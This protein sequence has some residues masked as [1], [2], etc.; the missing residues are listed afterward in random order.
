MKKKLIITILAAVCALTCFIGLTACGEDPVAV[1]GI[2]LN[3][4]SLPLEVGGEETL[5]ATVSPNNA[6]D[7]SVSWSSSAEAV[8]TVANGKVTA[9]AEGTATITAT[10]GKQSA[11]CA[12]TVSKKD[13]GKTDTV[14]VE[15]VTLSKSSLPLEVDG[16]ETLQATVLPANATDKTV[17]WASS[18]ESVATVTDGKV[19]AVGKGTATITATA[20]NQSATCAVSVQEKFIYVESISISNSELTLEIGAKETLTITFNPANATDKTVKW[21][22]QN[23]DV[24]TV[25]GGKVTAV[26]EGTTLIIADVSQFRVACSVTVVPSVVKAERVALDQTELNMAIGDE[27]TLKATVLPNDTADKSITWTSSDTAVATVDSDG[28]VTAIAAGSA[29]ITAKTANNMSATCTVTVAAPILVESVSLNQTELTIDTDEMIRLTA[30]VLPANAVNNNLTWESSDTNIVTVV[31]GNVTGMS[32]GTAVITAK[33]GGKSATC[34]VTV[35]PQINVSW[36]SL[37]VSSITVDLDSEVTLRAE[38][39]PEEAANMVRWS[40]ENTDVATVSENGTIIPVSVG[41]TKI[42]A[43]AGNK[44]AKCTVTIVE[45]VAIENITLGKTKISFDLHD[46]GSLSD[47]E[48]NV[49]PSGAYYKLS[50]IEWTSSNPAVA[51]I[52]NGDLKALSFGT[53]TINATIDGFDIEFTVNVTGFALDYIYDATSSNMLCTIVQGSYL[54]DKDVVIPERY[55]GEK[56][57]V[58]GNYAFA[59]MTNMESI[60]WPSS[61]KTVGEYAF[62]GCTSLKIINVSYLKDIGKYAFSG[63]TALEEITLAF[64]FMTIK[65]GTFKDCS[66]LSSVE[67]GLYS[68]SI[69]SY[70]FQNCISLENFDF[71]DVSTIGKNA[72]ENTGLISVDLSRPTSISSYAFANCSKLETAVYPTLGIVRVEKGI[73]SN[74]ENLKQITIKLNEKYPVIMPNAFENCQSLEKIVFEGTAEQWYGYTKGEDWNTNTGEYVVECAGTT[75][76]KAESSANPD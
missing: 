36:F 27:K 39:D 38:V 14:A 70:A 72:F 41:T 32:Q 44:T 63:C 23:K 2:T 56:I 48:L 29:T 13:D 58:I 65:E 75:L 9:V 54:V 16:E 50:Q 11:T 20:G 22:S 59:N 71:S 18:D 34:T 17:R 51:T 66:S 26:A 33:S 47:L 74:C 57:D 45:P 49:E 46:N 3:K 21:S 15:S 55:N 28:K 62:S 37:N 19:K 4:S 7:K 10:A 30:T 35:R 25:E 43:S 1:T 67:L 61:I 31:N 73:F 76:T 8:A 40:S 68:T 60:V 53:T 24:A 6:T 52:E 12:V 42:V 64:N 69:N 5:T